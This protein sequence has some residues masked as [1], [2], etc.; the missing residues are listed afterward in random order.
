[1]KQYNN[2]YE[3]YRSVLDEVHAPDNLTK[4]IKDMDTTHKKNYKMKW[5]PAAAACLAVVLVVTFII[6][7]FSVRTADLKNGFGLKTELNRDDYV[8]DVVAKITR[9]VNG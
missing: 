9:I 3:L 7:G 2:T 4:R 1:M 8:N 6:G 5:I